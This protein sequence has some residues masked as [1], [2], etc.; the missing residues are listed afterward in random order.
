MTQNPQHTKEAFDKI[1]DNYD[2]GDNANPILRWMRG[3]VH[4]I[5]LKNIKPGSSVLELNSGTGVDALFFA[6]NNINVLATDISSKMIDIINAKIINHHTSGIIKT[7]VKSFDEISG[8][9]ESNFDAVVSNFGGL[10]CIN[11]FEKLS[12]DLSEKLKPNGRFIA[13]VM[14][15]FCPWEM[16]YFLITFKFGKIFRRFN[17]NGIDADL[18]GEKVRTY[19]YSPCGFAKLFNKHFKTEKKYTLALYTPPP[20]LVGI[21]NKLKPL[22]KLWMKI[23]ELLMGI[24]PLVCFGDHFI[25]ILTKEN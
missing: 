10:N 9:K 20:Y 8:I 2:S 6:E 16:F 22:V 7:E 3:I 12:K 1:A 17:K 25:V 14:N 5:Y 13:V 11:D 18:N 19:Y 23:D 21:Y 24:F 4:K 15:K